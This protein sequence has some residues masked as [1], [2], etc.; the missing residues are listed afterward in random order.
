[1]QVFPRLAV[2][3]ASI[4][5]I[6]CGGSHMDSVTAPTMLQDP[7][8]NAVCKERPIFG[9]GAVGSPPKCVSFSGFEWV[10]KSAASS[11]PGPNRWVDDTGNVF[12]D[13]RGI[14]LKI[15]KRGEAWTSSQVILNKS[16]G[17]G[18]YIV[19][20]IGLDQLDP[21]SVLGIFT[22]DS[23]DHS[24]YNREID[25]EVSPRFSQTGQNGHFTVQPPNQTNSHEFDLKGGDVTHS[26]EWRADHITFTSGP[27]S[28]TY[29]G[30]NVPPTG[31][32]TLRI[33][34]WLYKSNPPATGRE[35]EVIISSF[36]FRP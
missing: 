6:C 15:T 9:E 17:Y 25:I 22:Y 2:D 35:V 21:N 5:L 11:G 23:L 29:T 3:I 8:P 4:M 1:M 7:Q 33:N 34:L 26:L 10:I 36:E 13:S 19:H 12:M 30:P 14:H 32:E 18:T 28:W 20:T 31:G 16:L 27:V 24:Y